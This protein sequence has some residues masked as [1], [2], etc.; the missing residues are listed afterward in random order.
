MTPPETKTT[1][2]VAGASAASRVLRADARRNRE[3]VLKAARRRFA[4]QGLDAQM[5][6]IAR[7]AG[8]GVGTVYRHFPTKDDLVEALITDRFDRLTEWTREALAE[9]D[10]WQAFCRLMYRSAELQANDR[11]LSEALASRP[12][13]MREAAISSGLYELAGQLVARAQASGGLREDAVTDDIPTVI[14]GLGRVTMAA[15]GEATMSWE[16]F[17]GIMLDGLRA[18]PDCRDLPYA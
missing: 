15:N 14:C 18:R 17:L 9:D 6:D 3:R 5:D 13:R 8:V 16:R 1:P 12:E 11:A 10:P 2:A 4:E 7:A